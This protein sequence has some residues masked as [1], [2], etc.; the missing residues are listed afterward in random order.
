MNALPFK[1]HEA[2]IDDIEDISL[3]Q[4]EVWLSTFPNDEHGITRADVEAEDFF[5]EE[6]L[7]QRERIIVD[8]NSNVRFWVARVGLKTIAYSCAKKIDGAGKIRSIY[9]LP[10]FQGKGVGKALMEA[11]LAW[12]D[13]KKPVKLSVAVY[14]DKAIEFYESLG[15]V[16]GKMLE[17]NPDGA[18]L[19]GKEVPEMEM[20][21][22][23]P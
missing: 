23:R 16:R 14:S 13:P 5:S 21:L 9:V 22:K 15:F 20:I 4:R 7:K 17:K 11:M 2:T 12:L 6:R 8:K 18:F 10:E 19:S 1:V 3:V